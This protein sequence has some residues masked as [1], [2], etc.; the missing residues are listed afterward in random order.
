MEHSSYN[1]SL[2]NEAKTP[3]FVL[4]FLGSLKDFF[5]FFLIAYHP[6]PSFLTELPTPDALCERVREEKA[7]KNEC[8]TLEGLYFSFF[9]FSF[10]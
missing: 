10:T 3:P 5:F 1:V 7:V 8:S 4:F 6:F 9:F 2:N